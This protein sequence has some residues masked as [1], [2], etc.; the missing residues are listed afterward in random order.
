[1]SI[2][3]EVLETTCCVVGGGPAGMMLGYLL[4]RRGVQVMVLEKHGDFFRDFRGDTVH[5]S[6]LD[7]LSELGLLKEFLDLPHQRVSSL[8]VII[9]D[10]SFKVADFLHVPASCKFVALMP[11]WDFLN[12]LSGQA[13]RFPSFRLLMQHEAIDLLTNGKRITGIVARNDAREVQ[14]RADL[15]VG[16]DGR[17][18]VMRNSAGLEVIEYGV[19]IDVLW[20]RISRKPDDPSQVLGNVNY[21]KALVL[22][23]R[24]DYF[25]AGL[26]IAKDSY[27]QIRANGLY[28]FR[29][30]IRKIA[31]Y[32][33]ERVNELQ[34]WEQIKILTVRI[35]RLQKWSRPGLLCI[36]DAAHA[37][38]PAGGV[39]INLA[40]QDAVAAANLLTQPL[41]DRYVSERTLAAV[42]KRREFPTRITQEVQ[43][44]A[45]RGFARVFENPGPLRA[46]WQ[47]KIAT[48]IPGIHR[49]LGYAVGI[50][51]RPEHV[52]ERK[53]RRMPMLKVMFVGVGVAAAIATFSWGAWRGWKRSTRFV[54]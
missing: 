5:P 19:P 15:V 53:S 50:G 21:G 20:F 2:T 30:N 40:I 26:I 41:L 24:A 9:G 23:N 13:K 34:S 16:C 47:A 33:R 35:N 38:S 11:Q 29:S 7:V 3:P 44:L 22:I 36:G 32:L 37:M 43:L 45:H 4:A 1:L 17:H 52:R 31:P 51:A 48:Q 28:A 18:S 6:T 27:D 10:S 25:Q 14:I 54:C 49:A 12:F 8:E 42:Q 39:G 46:P